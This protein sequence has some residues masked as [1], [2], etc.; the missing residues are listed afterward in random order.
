M[1]QTDSCL[2][3]HG[4][5]YIGYLLMFFVS[6][7]QLTESN[8]PHVWKTVGL[9]N[10]GPKFWLSSPLSIGAQKLPTFDVFWLLHN[11]MATLTANIF[12]MIQDIENLGTALETTK[13]PLHYCKMNSALQN[14]YMLHSA[15]LPAFAHGVINTTNQTLPDGRD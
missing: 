5:V 7:S 8:M 11:L 1:G 14:M 6:F 10:A 12:E 9:E 13:C 15:S 4:W 3:G 2:L